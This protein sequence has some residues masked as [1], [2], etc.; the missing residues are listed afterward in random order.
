MVLSKDDPLHQIAALKQL[1]KLLYDGSKTSVLTCQAQNELD[2][3]LAVLS[4]SGK[5]FLECPESPGPQEQRKLKIYHSILVDLKK[6]QRST[7]EVDSPELIEDVRAL[8]NDVTFGLSIM[9]AHMVVSSQ[10]KLNQMLRDYIVHVA[11]GR[12]DANIVSNL[13]KDGSFF[14]KDKAWRN[15]QQELQ[16]FGMTPEQ[17]HQEYDFI[18]MTLRKA[19]L[20][21]RLLGN[22]IPKPPAPEIPMPPSPTT[23]TNSSNAESRSSSE[24]SR[25][26][27]ESLDTESWENDSLPVDDI[28]VSVAVEIEVTNRQVAR[29]LPGRA[30]DDFPEARDIFNP[31]DGYD[32]Q[33]V[34]RPSL[35][36]KP[37]PSSI[38]SGSTDKTVPSFS[39]IPMRLGTRGRSASEGNFNRLSL[40][41]IPQVAVKRGKRPNLMSRMK[42]K[43]TNNKGELCSL[44][45]IGDVYGIKCAL[46]KGASANTENPL[47]QT[48][49]IIAAAFG[50]YDVVMLLMDHGAKLDAMGHGGETALSVA[51]LRGYG[52]IAELL[53]DRGADPNAASVFGKP[54]LSQAAGTGNLALTKLLL[55]FGADPNGITASGETALSYAATCDRYQVA[56]LL[57]RSGALVDKT[58]HAGRTPL[59]KAVGK[60]SSRMVQLLMDHGANPNRQDSRQQTPLIQAMQQG[61]SEILAIFLK[62]G[63]GPDNGSGSALGN[64][65]TMAGEISHRMSF[66]S[67]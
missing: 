59:L 42:F 20:E 50:H 60:G 67:T 32:S 31:L 1:A 63:Y 45:K 61:K 27:S 18:L 8:V 37:E 39:A 34:F 22:L 36:S 14:E 48:G 10:N 19:A 51:T 33:M 24:Y 2:Q 15:L 49:L 35:I 29:R 55:D 7:K 53:L 26:S 13:F 57:L 11:T 5:H 25:T 4:L 47:G 46:D 3:L 23:F 16:G 56:Q 30:L 38:R 6:L 54:A 9:N 64:L 28:P 41:A 66:F 52:D 65:G 40:S 44:V 62:H 17:S 58:G 12:R 21:S 43:M